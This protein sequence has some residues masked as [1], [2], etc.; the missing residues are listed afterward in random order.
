ML[1]KNPIIL[2]CFSR[3][4][5]NILWNILL[6]HPAVCSP[7]EETLQIFRLDARAPRRAGLQAAWLTRQRVFFDQ[8]NLRERAPISPHAQAFIDETLFH[9]KLKTLTDEEMRYKSGDALYTRPEVEHARLALK[10]N[11]GLLFLDERFHEMYPDATFFALV[12]DPLP[13]YESHKRHK[14]PVSRSPEAFAAFYETIACRMLADAKRSPAHHLLRFEDLLRAP[15]ESIRKVYALA[16]LDA[17]LTPQVRFK[18]KPHMQA[19]GSHAT[20]FTEGLHY[21]FSYED[22]PKLFEPEVNQ[23][24][25][26]KLAPGELEQLRAFTGGTRALLGYASP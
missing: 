20:R 21:W 4:G 10:N 15:A 5:S 23:Y 13:L 22:L 3:G 11:N 12:R 19:D 24:Q 7:I 1:N 25:V 16:G 9:W 18:A 14:T 6:S 2:N 8:W 26:S 17:S